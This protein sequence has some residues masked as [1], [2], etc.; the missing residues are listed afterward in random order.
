MPRHPAARS[1]PC[2]SPGGSRSRQSRRGVRKTHQARG[3]APA[4][5][6]AEGARSCF[7]RK[8]KKPKNQTAAT[9]VVGGGWERDPTS[10]WPALIAGACLHRGQ[11]AKYA[12][13]KEYY[14]APVLPKQ[15]HVAW[16]SQCPGTLMSHLSTGMAEAA[17]DTCSWVSEGAE[18][19]SQAV[20]TFCRKKQQFAL[21]LSS[22]AS[23]SS[24]SYSKSLSQTLSLCMRRG[25]L[26][27][28]DNDI[29][30]GHA[31]LQLSLRE[32]QQT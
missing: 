32:A 8:K 16:G 11:T 18:M 2:R 23:A 3:Q 17:P 15:R 1:S 9:S 13:S 7:W 4:G 14:T 24:A 10:S 30:G 21:S 25:H 19:P 20:L 27:E 6:R 31:H 29:E 12:S 5:E 28:Q 22:P 26:H